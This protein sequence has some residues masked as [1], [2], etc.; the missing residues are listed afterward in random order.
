M[1]SVIV[2]AGVSRW[3]SSRKI[4]R[5]RNREYTPKPNAYRTKHPA[6]A[7]NGLMVADCTRSAASCQHSKSAMELRNADFG[8]RNEETTPSEPRAQATGQDSRSRQQEEEH[9]HRSH[10]PARPL[11]ASRIP[12]YTF[13]GDPQGSTLK[14]KSHIS[15]FKS[16]ISN[17]RSQISDN[18][19]R[20]S[21][22]GIQSASAL[23]QSR[24]AATRSGAR[25]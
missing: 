5:L 4:R 10:A 18:R 21:D 9:K 15:N 20:I 19:Y 11:H 25:R 14:F 7:I 12:L 22:I 16:R 6:A 23:L 8:L 24:L 1:P 2:W 17:L 3:S 13:S